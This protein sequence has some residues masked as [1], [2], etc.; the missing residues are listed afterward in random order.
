M[1]SLADLV[2][3]RDSLS[4]ALLARQRAQPGLEA[5]AAALRRSLDEAMAERESLE[6]ER[7]RL[8]AE[9][10]ALRAASGGL[11]QVGRLAVRAAIPPTHP[12]RCY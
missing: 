8:A 3:E 7:A 11:R 10:E 12:S 6:R 2:R 9:A 5:E 4:A 1:A